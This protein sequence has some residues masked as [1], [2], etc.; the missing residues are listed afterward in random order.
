M[1]LL[2]AN[3]ITSLNDMHAFLLMDNA[4][5]ESLPIEGMD[6]IDDVKRK[7]QELTGVSPDQHRLKDGK[8]HQHIMKENRH[9]TRKDRARILA[10]PEHPEDGLKH[11]SKWL[12]LCWTVA[13]C[14]R[15][16]SLTSIAGI[17]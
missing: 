13:T 9:V 11:E 10:K 3:D 15:L 7:I 1:R 5:H 8:T 2:Q 14:I 12:T 17:V 16:G 6:Q 4:E